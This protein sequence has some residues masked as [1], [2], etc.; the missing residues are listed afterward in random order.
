MVF[1]LELVTK[2]QR[3]KTIMDGLESVQ[4]NSRDAAAR[5]ECTY[6]ILREHS[7]K[8]RGQVDAKVLVKALITELGKLGTSWS[9]EHLE[10]GLSESLGHPAQLAVHLNTFLSQ[11]SAG[12][13]KSPTRESNKLTPS[14]GDVV[15]Y[16]RSDSPL[17]SSWIELM[18]LGISPQTKAI[19]LMPFKICDQQMRGA[20]HPVQLSNCIKNISS[21]TKT[22]AGT[23][24]VKFLSK[25]KCDVMLLLNSKTGALVDIMD[26]SLQAQSSVTYELPITR[27]EYLALYT[28]NNDVHPLELLKSQILTLTGVCQIFREKLSLAEDTL[29]SALNQTESIG[30]GAEASSCELYN[31]IAQLMIMKHKQW[32]IDKKS[33]HEKET[34]IWLESEVTNRYIKMLLYY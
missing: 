1:A 17:M 23:D 33:R 22:V 20:A 18:E 9:Q 19:L 30:L 28:I 32:Q 14:W 7:A 25:I 4:K 24:I 13:H 6:R 10:R 34:Q 21:V 3:N 8:F 16:L 2:L 5:I 29:H 15:N 31:S 12:D 11:F 27:E 26:G